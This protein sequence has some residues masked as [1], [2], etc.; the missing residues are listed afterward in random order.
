MPWPKKLLVASV[1]ANLVFCPAA[2]ADQYSQKFSSGLSVDYDTN[3]LMQESGFE[4]IWKYKWNPLAS[5]T[6]SDERNTYNADISFRV[7]RSS[8][9]NLLIDREDPSA[10][11]GWQHNYERGLFGVTYGYSESSSRDSNLDETGN[12]GGDITRVTRK[13]GIQGTHEFSEAS[14]ISY[15][16]EYSRLTFQGDGVGSRSYSG[17]STLS[18]TQ[19]ERLQPYVQALINRY[20]P[21]DSTPS[22]NLYGVILGM[23]WDASSVMKLGVSAGLQQASGNV[24]DR[25][26]QGGANATYDLE[27]D[28]FTMAL[29]RSVSPRGNGGFIQSETAKLGWKRELAYNSRVGADLSLRWNNDDSSSQNHRFNLWYGH[30]LSERWDMRASWQAKEK[31]NDDGE[32]S[33][34]VVGLS[35]N[36]SFEKTQ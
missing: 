26:W 2:V 22:Q 28:Q 15:S 16:G 13:V 10:S 27:K 21:D 17:S 19:S 32:A 24:S 29:N 33:G 23:N 35:I 11:L 25:D 12:A 34:N 30:D 5:L 31:K 18:F 9:K 4:S 8:D 7:D 36:Y 1:L 6:K 3:P 20:V 14:L